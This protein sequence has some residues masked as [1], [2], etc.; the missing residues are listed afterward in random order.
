[1]NGLRYAAITAAFELLTLS[2]MPRLIR[3]LSKS[4]GVIFTLHRVLPDPVADFAPNSILQVT[5]GFLD[6]AITRVRDLGFDTVSIDEGLRRLKSDK[7]ERRFVVFSFDDAYRDN[8]VHALPLLRARKCPFVLYVPTAFVDG[9]GEVW[10]QALEDIIAQRGGLAIEQDGETEY[11]RCRT[12]AEKSALFGTVYK[13]MR[14]MD[15]DER[16]ALIRDIAARAGL[17]LGAHCR[18]LIMDWSEL[19]TFADEPLCTI[20][21][22]SVHH[23]ELSKLGAQRARSEILESLRTLEIQFGKRPRHFSYPIG[24]RAAAGQREYG[25]SQELGL[26]SAVTTLPGGLYRRHADLPWALPR[27]SLNGNFQ[28]VRYMS[29]FLSGALFSLVGRA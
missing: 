7:P 24:S 25:I 16:V 26:A 8:L 4:R 18:S 10:W 5:P 20:G 3:R 17:D 23:Y 29:V 11:H 21:A 6:A 9:V 27:I 14:R 19:Q 2:R 22:H 13:R 28:S 1:M 12:T 15:E